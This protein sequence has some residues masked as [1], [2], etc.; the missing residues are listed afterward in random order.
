MR[1]PAWINAQLLLNFMD[2][3]RVGPKVRCSRPFREPLASMK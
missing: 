2:A 3:A 1:L